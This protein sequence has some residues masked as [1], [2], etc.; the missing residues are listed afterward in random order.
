MSGAKFPAY[1]RL[2]RISNL[3]TVFSN[4]LLG[5]ALAAGAGPFP[6]EA[7][8]V[9]VLTTSFL[10]ISGMALNDLVDRHIDA[11]ERPERPI[12]SGV[13]SVRE[14]AIFVGICFSLPLAGVFLIAPRSTILAVALVV[15]I[16]LY[17]AFHKRWS[18]AL[19]F[20][21]LCRA[22]VYFLGAAITAEVMQR[23]V[24]VGEVVLFATLLS[25]YIIALTII[26]QKEVQ[27]GLGYRRWLAVALVFLPF[28]ALLA[29]APVSTAWTLFTGALLF[30]W[31][32]R[33]A[34][35]IR[36]QPPSVVPA[37]LGWL[38]GISLLDAFFLSFTQ[39]PALAIIA[40]GCFA[41]TV[42]G[43]RKIA[44]T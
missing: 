12:P 14:V 43:H 23:S 16:V 22:L 40:L 37:V 9:A 31:L 38:S 42:A 15:A 24:D 2:A 17:N 41:A 33:S 35:L 10:Y 28:S 19:V 27:G 11:A 18:G 30:T 4:V 26:A 5:V 3:P 21:G 8:L 36:K 39:R 1:L 6:W 34:R 20:M 29:T 13:L 7:T 32:A 44:G 25:I